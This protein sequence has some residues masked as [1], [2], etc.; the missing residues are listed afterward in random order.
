MRENPLNGVALLNIH[1]KII[2]KPEKEVYMYANK[3]PRRI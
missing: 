3:H 2:I 1:P